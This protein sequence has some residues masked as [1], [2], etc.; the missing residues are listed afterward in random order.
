MGLPGNLTI[1]AAKARRAEEASYRLG[2]RV[3]GIFDQEWH[4]EGA[5]PATE[6]SDETLLFDALRFAARTDPNPLT[7][8]MGN[9]GTGAGGGLSPRSLSILPPGL[10]GRFVWQLDPPACH[11]CAD[12]SGDGV[13][14]ESSSPL[15]AGDSMVDSMVDSE[16]PTRPIINEY[17]R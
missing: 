15:D 1:K 16:V 4:V 11:L 7:M 13:V 14:A 6:L 2:R 8:T 3:G 12:R 17:I 10:L 9:V 5:V